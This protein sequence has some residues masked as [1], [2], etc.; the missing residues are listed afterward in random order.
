MATKIVKTG[1][2]EA[3]V[4]TESTQTL[5]DTLIG[6]LTAPFDAFSAAKSS[7]FIDKK[8]AA[9]QIVGSMAV[10]A[11]AGY[12]WGPKVIARLS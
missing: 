8:S 7:E 4:Y 6:V 10:S 2:A 3:P 1:T 11:Y 5:S 12:A 9:I